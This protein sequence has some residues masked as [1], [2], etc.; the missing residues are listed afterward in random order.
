M[1]PLAVLIGIV[2]G[3]AC[4]L[5]V[6]LF[7]TWVTLLFL[8]ADDAGQLAAEKAPLGLAI[9]VFAVLT[10][11]SATSFYAQVRERGWRNAAHGVLLTTLAGA[12]WIYWPR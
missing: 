12:V 8:P 2:M 9:G 7:L 5:C 10:A 4:A 1:R 11:V 3:S 6:G